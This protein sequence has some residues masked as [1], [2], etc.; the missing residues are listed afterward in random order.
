MTTLKIQA[1]TETGCCVYTTIKVS[2]D[3]TMSE[4]VKEVKRRRYTMFRLTGT[5][6]RFVKI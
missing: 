3:Y 4:V 2:E 5:M 6:E 1:I